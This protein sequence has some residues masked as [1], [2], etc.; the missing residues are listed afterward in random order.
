MLASSASARDDEQGAFDAQDRHAE[1]RRDVDAMTTRLGGERPTTHQV[2]ADAQRLASGYRS[3]VPLVRTFRPADYALNRQVARRS[4]EWLARATA[5]YGRDPLVARAF[6]RSYDAIGGFYCDYGPF[7]RPGAFVAYAGATRLAQRL[8]LDG[9]DNNRFE[10][11]LERF[12]L[13]YGTLAAFNGAL[14]TSWTAPYDL[15]ESDPPRPEPTVA[16]KP[17]ELPDVDI[18][19]LDAEQ[20]AAWIE[21]Q[22]RFGSIAPRVYEARVLLNELS[23][24][25]QRQHIALHPVDAANALKMQGYLENAVDLVREGRFD[26][27][28]EALTRADYV[29]AKLKS[30]TGQ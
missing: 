9:R 16:L 17:V 6:L 26:T 30:V 24:R 13:A 2:I 15:P 29:R 4:L 28:I 7:Y 18:A 22:E 20:R 11:E 27:A 1:L 8:L 10:R 21:T 19:R 14:Q 12:A 23:D 3:I 5:L 25:L